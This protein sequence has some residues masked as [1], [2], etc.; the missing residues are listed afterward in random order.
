[1]LGVPG[2]TVRPPRLPITD[3]KALTAIR[4]VLEEFDL[5]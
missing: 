4:T 3:P 5:V 1:M 2:G